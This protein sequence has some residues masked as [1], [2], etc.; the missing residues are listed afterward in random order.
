[1]PEVGLQGR[2]YRRPAFASA[3]PQACRSMCGCTGN[4][5]LA[6]TP[7]RATSLAKPPVVKGAARSDVN[8]KGLAGS[9]SRLRLP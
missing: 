7:R 5:N 2:G 6:A 4:S 1:M 9:C 3:K 8:T